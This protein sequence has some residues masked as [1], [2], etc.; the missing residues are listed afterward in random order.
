M[1]IATRKN[2][3]K[4]PMRRRHPTQPS[5]LLGLGFGVSVR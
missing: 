5:A 4:I 2:K 3:A 1:T